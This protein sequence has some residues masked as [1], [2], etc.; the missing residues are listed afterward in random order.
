MKP[1]GIL[2]GVTLSPVGFFVASEAIL[3]G[4]HIERFDGHELLQHRP[5]LLNH[6]LA[7]NIA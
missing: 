7:R 3:V 2:E 4:G 1:E 5:R 6:Q